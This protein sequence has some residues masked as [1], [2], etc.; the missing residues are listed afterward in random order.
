M[1]S[2]EDELLIGFGPEPP[3]TD[4]LIN[5][6]LEQTLE[7]PLSF[8][9]GRLD[10]IYLQRFSLEFVPGICGGDGE[11]GLSCS[12]MCGDAG[13]GTMFRSWEV[14]WNCLALAAVWQASIAYTDRASRELLQDIEAR[15]S[16]NEQ[17][18]NI[19]SFDGMGVLNQTYA[20]AEASCRKDG[21]DCKAS[22]TFAEA[23]LAGNTTERSH[24]LNGTNFCEGV[25][26]VPNL[27]IAGP[28]VSGDIVF[29]PS[30]AKQSARQTLDGA[31]GLT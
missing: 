21:E 23:F 27:D 28:G 12:T 6:I 11:G 22:F 2:S 20:C 24:F 19:S 30:P 15:L 1:P 31:L 17:A 8:F 16:I 25:R 18:F 14:M 29:P 4:Q 3:S 5:K 10:N 26:A 13:T 7:A 9:Q